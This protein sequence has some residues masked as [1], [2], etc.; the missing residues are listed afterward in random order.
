MRRFIDGEAASNNAPVV[1]RRPP[2]EVLRFLAGGPEYPSRLFRT[3]G[4]SAEGFP[5]TRGDVMIQGS[6]LVA[7]PLGSEWRNRRP[8]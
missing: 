6:W 2:G 8:R 7:G 1:R 4:D 3:N 5:G